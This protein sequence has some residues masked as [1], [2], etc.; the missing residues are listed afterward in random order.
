MKT[1]G[2][3]ITLIGMPGSGKSTLGRMLASRLGYRF[4]D[5]DDLIRNTGRE[6]QEILDQEG[7]TAFLRLESRV[8]SSIRGDRLL[9]APGGSC[10]LSPE[11]MEHLRRISLVVFVD[12]PLEVLRSRLKD[13]PMRGIVGFRG[14]S[15]EELWAVRRPLYLRH[16]HLTVS[17]PSEDIDPA[18][19]FRALMDRVTEALEK[20]PASRRPPGDSTGLD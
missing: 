18:E 11:A 7:E 14:H 2:R 19:A 3:N 12:V 20:D 4:V 6:L 8:L 5:G 9:I 17:L 16:A 10:I 1:E 13:A 15:L